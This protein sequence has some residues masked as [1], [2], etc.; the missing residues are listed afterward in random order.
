MKLIAALVY[1]NVVLV[2]C[3]IAA[4]PRP[5][6]ANKPGKREFAETYTYISDKPVTM[7]IQ[8]HRKLQDEMWKAILKEDGPTITLTIGPISFDK[9]SVGASIRV[10]INMPTATAKTSIEDPHYVTSFLLTEGDLAGRDISYSFGLTSTLRAINGKKEKLL[11]LNREEGLSVTLIGIPENK[12]T[13]RI[14]FRGI[15]IETRP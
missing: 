15:R 14:P 10:F 1:L 4:N 6:V 9:K 5:Y 11:L 13:I 2:V 12:E 8:L 3:V 7:S